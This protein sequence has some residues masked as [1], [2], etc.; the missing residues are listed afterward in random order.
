MNNDLSVNILSDITVFTKY[1][2]YIPKL[3]R[4]E[5]WDEI[6]DRNK[7]M[8]TKKFPELK[9]EI[10]EAYEFVYAKKVLPSM[11]SMQF[12][13][14]PIEIS[15]NRIYN[16]AFLPVNAWQAFPEIIFMLLGG[17]GLGISVQKHHIE[18]LPHIQLPT[19]RPRRYLISD[20][21][22]GWADAVKVLMKSYFF[23][24]STINFDFSDIREKGAPLIT[25]G[26]KAPGPQ[27]LKECLLKIRGI[28]DQ[29]ENGDQL[30]SVEVFDI[31]C[32]IADAVLAGGIRRAAIITLF[33]ATDDDM[34]AAKTGKWYELNPQRGRSNN[35]ALLVR[36]KID[37]EFFLD[38]WEKIK[39]SGSGEPGIFFTNDKEWGVNPCGEVSLKSNTVCNLTEINGGNVVDE[40]DLFDRAKAASFIGTLQATYTDFHYLRRVW[41]RNT[42]KEALIGVGI[43]GIASGNVSDHNIEEAARLVKKEN[44]RVA[45]I[46]GI[47]AAA[48][49]TTI[50]PSGCLIP[51]TKIRTNIGTLTLEEIFD[52]NSY[53]IDKIKNLT[54]EFLEVKEKIFIYNENNE[55]E[56][57]TNLY[58]NGIKEL[59][60]VKIEMKD[61][62]IFECTPI[63]KFLTENRG[64]VEAQSLEETDEILSF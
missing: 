25:S 16:C 10:A 2:K 5:T 47:N 54:N 36:H 22:E 6:V 28:L 38:L 26:G 62:E 63:H 15:P 39:L 14:K 45:K 8:H 56:L 57:I 60:Y 23:S 30:T 59:E 12:A 42:E 29:K 50:K 3:K 53:P 31:V 55:K 20:S 24:G 27:P 7:K 44:K 41:Q 34:L 51:S 13:G 37:K 19:E 49:T 40:Q 1:A 9:K 11:R 61:G 32:H 46:L 52:S 43:T 35:S 58:V 48:R 4:R 17:S 33:S 64:W 21:I 18:A